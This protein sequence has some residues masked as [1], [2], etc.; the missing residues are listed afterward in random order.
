MNAGRCVRVLWL[1][2]ATLAATSGLFA[3]QK[4][5]EDEPPPENERACLA[6]RDMPNLTITYAELK[7]ATSSTPSYC[8]IKG[9]ISPAIRYHLQLP[10][11][12]NWNGRFLMWGDGGTDG[13]LDF[14]DHRLGEGYAV[15]NSNSGHDQGSE[16]GYSFAYNNLQA[17]I[18]FG[19][20]AEHLTINAAKTV[21]KAYYR[22][23]AQKSY[24]EGCS[25][26]GRE[27]MMEAQR[28]PDDFDGI[29]VGSPPIFNQVLFA[30]R[31]SLYQRLFRD[32]FEGNLAFDS[33]GDGS[34]DSV[35][36]LNI[37]KEAVLAK[38]DAID[39]IVDGVIDNP[40]ACPF[41]PDV[42]LKNKMCPGDK[43]ANNCLTAAQLQT[44]KDIYGGARDSKG[45][46]ISKGRALG[47]EFGW[48]KHLIPYTG[49][50]FVP[51]GLRLAADRMN[52]FF[53]ETD[54][55]PGYSWTKF[56]ID[57]VTAGLGD[58]ISS[59]IDAKDPNLTPFLA[60]NGGKLIVYHGWGDA[61]VPPEPTIDY[62]KDVVTKTFGN[63][64][65]AATRDIRLFMVPGMDHCKGGPGPDTW[66]K[67]AP[68]VNW[69]EKG[70]APDFLIAT[71]S[72]NSK[73]DNERRICPYPQRAVYSGPVGTQNDSANWVQG[74]FVC[75]EN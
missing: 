17:K 25:L 23:N 73:V 15:A 30:T 24:F 40:L 36:K 38:C 29:V 42:D 22:K 56:N 28:Y 72:T 18:D 10:L 47:S 54:P 4:V 14:T 63:N 55:P 48:P 67:L 1:V 75:R 13:I 31:I 69:V 61:L 19:Y 71:H 68:L 49:N 8:Y 58:F 26:G 37:L 70:N 33:K 45:Q 32:H 74:N 9:T 52:Y 27:G 60:N 51:S 21:I 41:S 6:L 66:D 2:T 62:Y 39:G 16:P 59:I 3:G 43:N 50:S 7:A 11:P 64:L 53:Y 5:D 34:P 46:F 35:N 65:K 57:D 12:K 20:R 44:I